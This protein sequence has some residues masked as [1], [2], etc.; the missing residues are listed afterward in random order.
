MIRQSFFTIF[1]LMES[2]HCSLSNFLNFIA[3]ENGRE[4]NFYLILILS[5]SLNFVQI[6]SP[7]GKNPQKRLSH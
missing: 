6:N 5:T 3:Q 2:E 7:G 1:L 4:N